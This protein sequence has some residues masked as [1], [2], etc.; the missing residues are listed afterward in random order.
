MKTATPKR[1]DLIYPEL[2]YQ[3][4]GIL[5][6]VYNGLGPGYQ[7]KYYQKAIAAA[8]RDCNLSFKEYVHSPLHFKG[9][10]VGSYYLDFLIADKIV[11]EIKKSE[12]FS[13]NNIEQLYAYLR[14]TG[15]KLGILAHFGKAGLKFKRIL[16]VQ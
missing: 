13:R 16:N 14:N 2:S 4:I 15:H 9:T 8:L 6:E 10:K 5:F 11:L 12:R 3:I 7:E 1:K